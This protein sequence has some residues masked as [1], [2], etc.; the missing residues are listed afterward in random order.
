MSQGPRPARLGPLAVLAA[1]VALVAGYVNDCFSGLGFAPAP[2]GRVDEVREVPR[3]ERAPAASGEVTRT[4]ILVQG[5]Q[6]RVGEAAARACDLVCAE[7]APNAEVDVE[8]TTGTQKTVEAL[9]ACLKER[10]VKA[11]MVAE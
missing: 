9:R 7:L 1:L 2:G 6:C 8:A 4:R 11:H 10:G 3:E 5:E